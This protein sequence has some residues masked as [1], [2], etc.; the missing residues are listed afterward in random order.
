MRRIV[1]GGGLL[2]SLTLALIVSAATAHSAR[3]NRQHARPK[4]TVIGRSERVAGGRVTAALAVHNAG[5]TRAARSS[6]TLS[7]RLGHRRWTLRSASIGQVRAGRTS[8]VMLSARLPAHLAA[9]LY[10]V[11]A[12]DGSCARLGSFRIN[13]VTHTL[14]P[15]HAPPP[16][17]TPAPTHMPAP[18]PPTSTVPSNPIPFTSDAPQHVVASSVDY[19]V[20]APPSY[21]ATGHTPMTLF[22]WLH[23]CGGESSG[24]IYT[25]DPGDDRN[26]L[27]MTVG[28]REDDCWNP[29]TDVPTVLAAIADVRTH[30]NV[31]PR[32]VIL[33]GYS[34]GGDLAYRTMF[35]N[36]NVF[37]GLLAVNTSP[38]R[39]TGMS[40]AQL[41]AAAARKFPVVHLAHLQDATYPFDPGVKQ[42][43]AAMKNAGFPVTL[44]TTPG[45]H[46]DNSGHKGLP[47]TDADTVNLLLPHIDDGWLAPG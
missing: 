26:Y 38:F 3:P 44:V 41:L 9:G 25:V 7:I 33:G 6:I 11:W 31:D 1:A 35:L 45:D 24:D 46:Y 29:S 20:D 47:G 43:I 21:D 22:V 13:A 27:T 28:G 19:W 15:K 12:C 36:A 30:F 14:P 4:L 40:Q 42:E 23:G 18:P 34:S 37:A 16:Q 39:D 17:R 2:A 5:T 10:A 8:E 32:R